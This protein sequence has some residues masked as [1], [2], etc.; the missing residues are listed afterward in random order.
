MEKPELTLP[1]GAYRVALCDVLDKLLACRDGDSAL[2][3]LYCLRN[4]TPKTPAEERTATAFLGFSQER[5]DRAWF[6]L[7]S[8]TISQIST[9]SSPTA[10]GAPVYPVSELREQRKQDNGFSA[11][12][13]TAEN[14]LR[15]PLT[16]SQL[17]Q[18]YTAYEHLGLS[19]D[20]IIELLS[21]LK[22]D[23]GVIRVSDLRQECYLWADMGIYSGE[24]AQ[25]YLSRLN[26]EIPLA[27]SLLTEI[28][29][30]DRALKPPERRLVTFALAHAFPPE[31]LTLAIRRAKERIGKFSVDYIRGILD[32]WDKKGL[33][34]IAEITALE[35]E[36]ERKNTSA[37]TAQRSADNDRLASWEKDWLE[38]VARR[39]NK[40][41]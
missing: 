20:A 27:K 2:L 25:G 9:Q 38:E 8:L 18:L 30:Q 32:T 4:G 31:V 24:Q 11:V 17:R 14:L 21:Y 13:N 12:C 15:K 10:E 40:E 7:S 6:T 23:R 41:E 19:A 36:A 37:T 35:P 22:N 1:D 26:A 3:Y 33:H 34:T 29:S 5:L 39:K 28:G 16:E